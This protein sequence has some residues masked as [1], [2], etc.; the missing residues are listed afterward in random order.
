MP[1]PVPVQ[2]RVLVKHGAL[3]L[4]VPLERDGVPAEEE[5]S[6]NGPLE[7][8]G[9]GREGRG[10]PEAFVLPRHVNGRRIQILEY[11]ISVVAKRK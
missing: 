6:C 10:T 1:Q 4:V 7:R 2:H 5:A 9:G 11:H 3:L 8:A